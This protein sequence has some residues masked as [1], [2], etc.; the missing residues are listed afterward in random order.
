MCVLEERVFVLFGSLVGH[1]PLSFCEI[2]AHLVLDRDF[3]L[4]NHI[5]ALKEK[6]SYVVTSQEMEFPMAGASKQRLEELLW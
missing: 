3:F 2:N 4:K 6:K 1:K 5:C